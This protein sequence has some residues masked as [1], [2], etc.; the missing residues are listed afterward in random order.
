MRRGW[1]AGGVVAGGVAAGGI[2]GGMDAA[3]ETS[4]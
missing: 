1:G 4:P 2:T 3:D